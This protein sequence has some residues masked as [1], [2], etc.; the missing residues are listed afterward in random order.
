M[1]RFLQTF[2][3]Q[4]A[5]DV[6]AFIGQWPTRLQSSASAKDLSAM[7][8]RYQLEGLCVSH[9]ASIFGFDTRSGNEALF[10][11]TSGDKRLW[12]FPILNPSEPGWE[13]ELEWAAKAGARGIRL[14]PGYQRYS[15]LSPEVQQ[16]A[17]AA[18]EIKLPLHVCAR[19]EDERL[20]HPLF[21]AKTVPFHELAEL[22]RMCEGSPLIISGLRAGEHGYVKELLN[23]GFNADNVLFD[24]WFANG[25]LA[26]ISVLCKSGA[27]RHA[28]YGSCTPIQV[29]EATAF[30][31]GSADISETERAG[32][33][34]NNALR[35]LA[36]R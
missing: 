22:I 2:A 25:P 15:L 11:D 10:A 17:K 19:L 4:R 12:P 32:L 23:D 21:Q 30:Q 14:V 7:A 6:T 27:S 8:D 33:C 28:A 26:A 31:L 13:W 24:L 1:N 3:S 20:Q 9:I 18:A 34:R 29:M 36:S 16:L 35:L 5:I